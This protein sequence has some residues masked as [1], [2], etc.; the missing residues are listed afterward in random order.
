[1]NLSSLTSLYVYNKIPN[2]TD[3]LTSILISIVQ[4]KK[5]KEASKRRKKEFSKV[6]DHLRLFWFRRPNW[7]LRFIQLVLLIATS[8]IGVAVYFAYSYTKNLDPEEDEPPTYVVI[9]PFIPLLLIFAILVPTLLMLLV[10]IMVK[11][12]YIFYL[13]WTHNNAPHC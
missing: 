12:L 4:K 2:F 11:C 13:I 5:I 6:T 3:S 8:L 10:K 9:I 7:L 1:M